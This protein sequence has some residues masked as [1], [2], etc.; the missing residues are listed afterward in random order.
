MDLPEIGQF[1]KRTGHLGS[2]GWFDIKLD[3]FAPSV[4]RSGV[5]DLDFD[6][7]VDSPSVYVDSLIDQPRLADGECRITETM[8]ETAQDRCISHSQSSIA[9]K[10]VF[11]VVAFAVR[12]RVVRVRRVVRKSMS[13]RDG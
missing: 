8:A 11:V 5:G 13:E 3:D 7:N 1:A 6:L 2:R 12:T 9:H 10:H 4:F